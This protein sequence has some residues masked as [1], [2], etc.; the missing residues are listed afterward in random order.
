LPKTKPRQ[1]KN[2]HEGW[3]IDAKEEMRLADG[4]KSS[5]LN[6]TDEYSGMVIDPPVFPQKENQ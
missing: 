4:S 2:L 3:Q 5:W 1:A 6:I